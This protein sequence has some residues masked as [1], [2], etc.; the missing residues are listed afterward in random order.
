MAPGETSDGRLA[1]ALAACAARIEPALRALLDRAESDGAPALLVSAMRHAVLDGGKRIRPFLV[2][3]T[4]RL[5]GGDEEAAM[6]GALAVE[7]VHGYSLVHDDLPAMDDDAMRRGKP[8]VHVLHGDAVGILVGD[9][10]QALAFEAIARP[11]VDPA[12]GLA[13]VRALAIGAGP[14]GMVGGQL[15][16]LAAEGRFDAAG[17]ERMKVERRPLSGDP[18]SIAAIQNLK[19][20]ALIRAAVAMGAASAP[21]AGAEAAAVLDR[22][23][24]ALG[25]AF[26]IS[27]DILDA[28]GDASAAGKALAKD[29]AAG[30]GTFVSALGLPGAKAR[31]EATIGSGLAA[32]DALGRPAPLHAA[33]LRS[34]A[35]RGA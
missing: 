26:Q 28:E 33:L 22:Y 23:A 16:D 10:L 9:A 29:A 24:A 6:R 20:G 35:G 1:A 27:D 12:I 13:M 5:L 25:A 8:T 11:G 3:E 14:A 31:L 19:T 15:L 32:L 30:K 7:L 17:R 2:I 18:A 4:A 21:A 34:M